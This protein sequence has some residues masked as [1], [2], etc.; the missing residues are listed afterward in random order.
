MELGKKI[1]TD[2]IKKI[3]I[4]FVGILIL[5]FGLAVIT[6][7]NVGKSIYTNVSLGLRDVLKKYFNIQVTIG[8]TFLFVDVVIGLLAY[9]LFLA[10]GIKKKLIGTLIVAVSIGLFI[11]FWIWILNIPDLTQMFPFWIRFLMVF[12]L[13]FLLTFGVALTISAHIIVPPLDLLTLYVSKKLDKSFSIAKTILIVIFLLIGLS[14]MTLSGDFSHI[15]VVSFI[16]SF[17]NG[18]TIQMWLKVTS[19]IYDFVMRL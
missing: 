12:P 18:P 15:S 10:L 9:F 6:Q 4:S 3:L 11:D 19:K 16:F 14:F 2:D 17:A 7:L 8:T 13:M 1:F 5:A